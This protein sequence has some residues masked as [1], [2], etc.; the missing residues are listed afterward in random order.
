MGTKFISWDLI[1]LLTLKY[2]FLKPV[3]LRY[4]MT[5]KIILIS[6]TKCLAFKRIMLSNLPSAT[7]SFEDFILNVD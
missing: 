4:Y 5:V 7:I 3:I 2:V 1:N 6:I